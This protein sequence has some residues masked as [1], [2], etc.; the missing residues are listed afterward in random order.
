[1]SLAFSHALWRLVFEPHRWDKTAHAPEPVCTE[2]I[3][4]D[5]VPVT[6]RQAA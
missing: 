3:E 1:L 4:N 2:T 6:G 5:L